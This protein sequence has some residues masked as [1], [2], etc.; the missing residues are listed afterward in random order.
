MSDQ[1]PVRVAISLGSNLSEPMV[2]ITQALIEL[3]QLPSTRL[4]AQSPL[5]QSR[6][7]GPEQPDYINA[8]ALL[9]TQLAPHDLLDALQ[10][11]EQQ[12]QRVRLEHWGP[13]SL[14]LD[15]LLYGQASINTERLTVPHAYLRQRNF[16]LVPLHDI[17]PEALLP[18]GE[19]IASL[20][21]NCTMD[22]LSPITP[23]ANHKE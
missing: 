10:A 22:G 7:V 12:H 5:Y 18:S 15:L 20:R 11:L 16:V 2:Q 23:Q 13:R 21:A 19:S 8:C 17:W 4:L 3:G 1:P 9:E 6:A 14:D